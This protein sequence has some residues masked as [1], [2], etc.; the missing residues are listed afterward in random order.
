MVIRAFG[1]SLL[2]T[3]VSL[4]SVTWI[5]GWNAGFIALILI[6]VEI[7]F[8]FDNAIINARVLERLAAVWQK[9]FLTIGAVVAIFGMRLLFPLL[10]VSV[11]EHSTIRSVADLALHHPSEYAA[12]LDSVHV[13][14]AAFGGA[15]LLT[16]ALQFFL[17]DEREELWLERLERSLQRLSK[18]WLSAPIAIGAVLLTAIIPSN[19]NPR[20]T[21]VAGVLGV[22]IFSLL[23][24]FNFAVSRVQRASEHKGGRQRGLAALMLFLY[25]QILDAS[26]S[27]DSVIGA[28]AIT[29]KIILIFI[30]LAVGALWVRSL[31]VYIVQNHT[32]QKYK[33]LDHGAHYAILVLAIILLIS[34]IVNVPDMVAGIMGVTIIIASL[35]ASK[36]A[37]DA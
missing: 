7:V 31:T 34:T 22:V 32:I 25:L 1:F 33:Y 20:E 36:K 30:G 26:F 27:F 12:K 10:L 21:I 9:L 37:L 3:G 15:F 18:V 4:F 29:D 28:F 19:D 2:L 5:F 35:Y 11:T 16:L 8:S 17:D 13:S 23:Q 6:A 24:L 14:I